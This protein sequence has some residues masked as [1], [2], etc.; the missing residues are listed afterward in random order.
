[1]SVLTGLPSGL[2]PGTSTGTVTLDPATLI[3]QF[4]ITGLFATSSNWTQVGFTF[5][6]P[7]GGQYDC[8]TFHMPTLTATMSVSATAIHGTWI[9]KS[10]NII[11]GD[12][13][14]YVIHRNGSNFDEFNLNVPIN[15]INTV[16]LMHL[17]GNLLDSSSYNRTATTIGTIT[18]GT[19]QTGF[20][21]DLAADVGVG[22]GFTIPS[23][24]AFDFGTGDFT[25]EFWMKP[26]SV[27][28]SGNVIT[29]NVSSSGTSGSDW[30]VYR[31]PS[32]DQLIFTFVD[33]GSQTNFLRV[34]NT[35]MTTGVWYFWAYVRAA[36]VGT[37]YKN[38]VAISGTTFGNLSNAMQYTNGK[39]IWM[40]STTADGSFQ[41][42]QELDEVRISNVARYLSNFTP[43]SAPFS[44]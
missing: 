8:L 5:D 29:K 31:L 14:E 2:D 41:N 26:S 27:S 3:S 34:D 33:T 17:D 4:G 20:A 16:L 36:G 42:N 23:D 12:S 30:A 38:G 11:D 1:M 18:Y 35:L 13:G 6:S 43:P 21:Q 24:S 44:S 37:W 15:D 7:T 19:G 10:I 28:N 32:P 22:N 39:P 40:G 9:L 25:I